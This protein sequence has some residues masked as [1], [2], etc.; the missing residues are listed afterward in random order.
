MKENSNES[1]KISREIFWIALRLNGEQIEG[2]VFVLRILH[3]KYLRDS[4]HVF[5]IIFNK[6]IKV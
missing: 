1:L 4:I 3:V 6:D 5:S 2:F